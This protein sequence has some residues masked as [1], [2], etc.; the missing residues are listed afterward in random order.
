MKGIFE[1]VL[2]YDRLFKRVA[3]RLKLNMGDSCS[4]CNLEQPTKGATE[5]WRHKARTSDHTVRRSFWWLIKNTLSNST[6]VL[7]F[8][9]HLPV[10]SLFLGIQYSSICTINLII[11]LVCN[12]TRLA[13]FVDVLK[14]STITKMENIPPFVKYKAPYID[15]A[16]SSAV[17]KF[18]SPPPTER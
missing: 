3:P 7:T 14:K 17:E 15:K 9:P 6:V 13:H 12:L 4:L 8:K 2:G 16:W 1:S 18:N 11:S 10:N 5:S